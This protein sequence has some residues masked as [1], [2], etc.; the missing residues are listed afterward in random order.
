[1][2]SE[3]GH[4]SFFGRL[5]VFLLTLLAV[6]GLM[7]MVLSVASSY[8]D[9]AQFVWLSYFGLAFWAILL[10]NLIIFGLLLLMWS[11][12]AWVAVLAILVSIPGVYRSFS[13]GKAQEGGDIRLM[14][15]N[16]HRF[17]Y[18]KDKTNTEMA[19]DMVA[20]VNEYHPD[21]LC[22]QEFTV[23]KPK[24]NRKDCIAQFGEM[25]GMPFQYY[26]SKANFGGNVIFSKYPLS[27]VEDENDYGKENRYGTV[28]LVDAGEKGRFVVFCCHLT[29]FQITD[30]EINVFTDKEN[31]KED[32]KSSGKSIISKLKIAYQ[33]RSEEVSKMLEDVPHDGRAIVL[34]GDFN[35][36]PLSYTYHQIRRAG[37]T[38]GFVKTGRGIGH[39]YAGKLPLLRIDYVWG[40]DRIQPMLFK[41]IKIKGSDH[42]PVLMD[43]NVN[44]EF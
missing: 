8:V 37:F 4:R 14:T 29:S 15:Y 42:Y 13:F 40:N 21:V 2:G 23:F 36:T 6:V 39:T 1:M 24:T 26:N 11:R 30:Q 35:D 44:H 17:T 12:K 41:R 20:M 32:V 34:C 10:F 28:A 7:A 16:V 3:R 25:V 27:A 33:K 5:I 18:L 38:D 22:L 43:F 19:E 9:P 31:S